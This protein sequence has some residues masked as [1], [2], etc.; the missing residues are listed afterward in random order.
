[1]QMCAHACHGVSSITLCLSLLS[2]IF[3]LN[4]EFDVLCC[5]PGWRPR[6]LERSFYTSPAYQMWSY[7]RTAYLT[8]LVG[9]GDLNSGI[10]ACTVN[11]LTTEL[12]PQL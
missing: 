7:R 11:N 3:S 9:A 1:M 4:L 10:H 12:S 5:L 2:Q 8:F 6:K